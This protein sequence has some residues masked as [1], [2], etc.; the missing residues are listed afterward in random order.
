MATG[1]RIGPVDTIWLNMD[2]PENL[3]VIESIFLLERSPDWERVLEVVRTRMVEPY[4][5][6]QERPVPPRRPWEMPRWEHDP[7]FRLERH[8]RRVRLPAPG[9]DAALQ[10]YVDRHLHQ[11]L[12]RRHPLWQVHF[13]DGYRGGAA[14]FCRVHHSL[15]D[16]IALTRVVLSMTDPAPRAPR[17]GSVPLPGT[18]GG[19]Q[20]AARAL[21]P[22]GVLDV[23][24]L[25]VRTGQVARA[26]LLSNNPA[27]V[28]GGQPE[29]RKHVVWSQ[30]FPLDDLKAIGRL[31]GAT[32][33]DVL[34]S[35]V[36][37]ALHRYQEQ[38]GAVPV[39]LTTMVPVN[40][41]PL[42]RELPPTLGNRFALVFFTFPSAVAAPLQRL[43]ETK[44]RMDWLKRSPES[45]ITFGLIMAIGRTVADLER[46]VVNFFANKAIGVT[47]N[48]AGPTQ[49]RYL[50]GTKVTGILGWVPGSGRHTVGVCIFTYA[51]TV[52]VGFRVDAARVRRPKRLLAAFESELSDLVD[53]AHAHH[54]PAAETLA[55]GGRRRAH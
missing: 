15:A 51:G 20:S 17:G 12:D 47:T 1:R 37:G 35:A 2:R 19:L 10:R 23:G 9:D 33:N 48:V 45:I 18:A 34:M 40:V 46:Y 8:V 44:R 21:V 24:R 50:A 27:S 54:E 3:M 13:I 6:F 32:L 22:G 53:L 41:R 28:L 55:G 29:L 36:A 5:V 16:G 30:P 39:D 42:D 31:C 26:L 11:P 49:E 25:A 43:A 7:D 52:R 14:V 4:P 38:E